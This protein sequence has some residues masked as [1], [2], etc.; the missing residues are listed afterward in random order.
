MTSRSRSQEGEKTRLPAFL[1]KSRRVLAAVLSVVWLAASGAWSPVAAQEAAGGATTETV[2]GGA[3]ENSEQGAEAPLT[4]SER[5]FFADL[6]ELTKHPHRL[7]GSDAGREA[8]AYIEAGLRR[9]GVREIYPLDMPVW[10]PVTEQ[11]ELTIGDRT[12]RLYPLRPNVLV[13][14]VTPPEGVRAPLMYAG[15][16]TYPDYGSRNPEGAIVVLD[17]ASESGFRRAMALG[18]RGVI[19]LGRGDEAPWAPKHAVVPSNQLR[20]YAPESELGGVDLRVDQAEVTL[21]SRLRWR[22]RRGRSVVA[23]VAGTDPGF[24]PDRKEAESVVIATGFDSFGVV[25]ELAPGARAAA[26]AALLLEIAGQLAAAPVKRDALLMFLDGQ[27][28]AQQGAREVYA[29]LHMEKAE[30]EALSRERRE[31]QALVRAMSEL[32]AREGLRFGANEADPSGANAARWLELALTAETGNARDDVRKELSVLRLSAKKDAARIKTLEDSWRRWDAIRRALH[33]GTLV[34]FVGVWEDAARTA[35][36]GSEAALE[37]A[38][39]ARMFEQVKAATF[40]RFE[41]RA[42]ELEGEIAAAEQRGAMRSALG[43]TGGDDATWIALHV[44]L[45]LGGGAPKWGF[46]A[47]DYTGVFFNWRATKPEGD[48]PG[49]YGRVLNV[50]S[51]TEPR[52]HAPSLDPTTLADPTSG[53]TFAAGPFVSTGSAAGGYGIY[54]L[55]VMTGNDVRLRDGHPAD[56]AQRLDWRRLREQGI[57]SARV[58]RDVADRAEL[59]LPRVFAPLARSKYPRFS[60]GR[61]E[62]NYAGLTV[63]GSLSED[64]PATGALLATWPGEVDWKRQ[65]WNSLSDADWMPGYD[66]VSF[67]RVDANGRFRLLG[68][69]SDLFEEVMTIGALFDDQGQVRAIT[70]TEKQTQKLVD[71]MRV[72]LFFATGGNWSVLTAS[73]PFPRPDRFKLMKASSDS[74]FADNRSLWGVQ[75]GQG[76]FYVSDQFVDYKVKLFQPSGDVALGQFSAEHPFGTGLDPA[77]FRQGINLAEHTARDLWQLNESRLQKL[78]E[79]GVTSADLEQLHARAQASLDRVRAAPTLALREAAVARSVALSQRVYQPIRS[80]MDDLVYAIVVLL[81]LTIPFAFSLERL[82][83]GASGV[84]GRI[85]GFVAMFMGTFAILFVLH[86]GFSIASTPVIIFLAFAILLLSSLVI[87]IVLRKFK[88]E[89]R[90]MQG[91]S[92]GLHDV[93]VSH[94]STLL[95][96]V[97]MG[98]STMRRRPTRTFLTAVTVV[99]LTFTILSFASFTQDIGIRSVY[100]GPVSEQTPASLLI[101]KLDYSNMP[102]SVVDALEGEQ[103]AGGLLVPHLWLVR[104]IPAEP[105]F[106][107]ARV[108]TGRSLSI[109]AVM[110]IAPEQLERWPEVSQALGDSSNA[111]K[112]QTLQSGA[113]YLPPVVQE[114]LEL[115]P[116]DPVLV[117]GQE[118]KFA[119]VHD[120]SALQRIKHLDN[121]SILPVDFVSAI[122]QSEQGAGQGQASEAQLLLAEESDRAFIHLSSDQVAL[123]SAETVRQLGGSVYAIT[124]H[125]GPGVDISERGRRIAEATVMPVW[126]AT[127]HGVERLILTRLTQVSGGLGLFVPLLLGGLI[128]FG[129]LL[130]SISDREKEIYTFSALGLSPVHVGV[131]FFAEAAVYAFVGGVGGQLLAQ[132]VGL[133]A[134]VLSEAGLMQPASLNYSST[135]ALFATGVVMLTVLVS[136]IYPAVRASRSANPGVARTWK[137]PAPNG[138]QLALTFPF[139]VSAYDITGVVS[140]LAEHFRRHDDAGLGSFAASHVR[141]GKSP[142]GN[143]EL[144]SDLAL[145]P[146]DLGVTQ[147]MK[148]TAVPSQI[149]GVDEVAI[150][151]ERKSGAGADWYRANRVFIKELRRQFLVWRTLSSETIEGYRKHTLE[152]LGSLAAPEPLREAGE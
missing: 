51:D 86:P 67:E 47:G 114:V 97:G 71:T 115:R 120:G 146:F 98:M 69:R 144:S 80:T 111:D 135:N 110:G 147:H 26:N 150:V 127:P 118:L 66:P 14:P 59:S 45:S 20:F 132:A 22:P 7:A 92:A 32:L 63:S 130:G 50:V 108:D 112:A 37:A 58:L 2:P 93:E 1:F 38:E 107:V 113:I 24:A 90:V 10:E 29:A 83:I 77:L 142:A 40:A 70:T 25:P 56:T 137:M 60:G 8:A 149:P 81:L 139:T 151:V 104:T 35:P 103:G 94:M 15:E 101:R 16:G 53:A 152:V 128:I 73:Q 78:R 34:V 76:F 18:A 33:E 89:L 30:A 17:Y 91:Q 5:A 31:E 95:A 54:N 21:Q 65:A 143:L 3:P 136:A 133:G 75:A 102:R 9:R 72:N 52:R 84:Y 119:G 28:R 11:C 145:A 61:S 124:V 87:Y 117:N 148:L 100:E 49:Y 64:R 99:M 134:R 27:G 121:Q 125:A 42:A 48:A 4:D 126:S 88:A 138:D 41:L 140:F 62:G 123:A 44:D 79:R 46:V 19:F 82:L 96:A 141:L 116:G 6:S 122:T 43:F 55:S 129:T 106:S 109:D 39:Y 57:E 36:P 12:V 131:L 68:L 13:L 105:R 85:G 74:L 23:R